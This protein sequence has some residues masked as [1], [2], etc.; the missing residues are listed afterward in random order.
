MTPIFTQVIKHT[1]LVRYVFLTSNLQAFAVYSCFAVISVGA[2][3][4][5]YS[6]TL[7]RVN[8]EVIGTTVRALK[9][10][11]RKKCLFTSESNPGPSA[12]CRLF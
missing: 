5:M 8:C 10:R 1:T 12:R 7:F 4:M 9:S 6:R 11:I 2:L 3:L